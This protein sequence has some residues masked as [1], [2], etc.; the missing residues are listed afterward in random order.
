[1]HPSKTCFDPL[2]GEEVGHITRTSEEFGR[3]G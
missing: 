2:S 3:P 1:M